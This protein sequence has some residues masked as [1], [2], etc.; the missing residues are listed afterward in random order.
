MWKSIASLSPASHEG[1]PYV[2]APFATAS[3]RPSHREH[4]GHEG[5]HFVL[6]VSRWPSVSVSPWPLVKY[7]SAGQLQTLQRAGAVAERLLADAGL[8]EHRDQQVRH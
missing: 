4:R 6:I 1:P 8:V 7:R 3:P 5:F 2:R